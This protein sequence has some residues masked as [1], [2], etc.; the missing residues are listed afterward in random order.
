[1]EITEKVK[2]LEKEIQDQKLK[3]NNFEERL[4]NVKTFINSIKDSNANSGPIKPP[5][6]LIESNENLEKEIREQ[7]FKVTNIRKN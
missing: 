1:M 6:V 4:K 5:E 2:E 3:I 7:R